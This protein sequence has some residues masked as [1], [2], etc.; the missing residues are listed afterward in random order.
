MGSG[1]SINQKALKEAEPKR[2]HS[3][4]NEIHPKQR[5][6]RTKRSQIKPSDSTAANKKSTNLSIFRETQAKIL[7]C[8]MRPVA[9]SDVLFMSQRA[10]AQ[11]MFRMPGVNDGDASL[12]KR[13]LSNAGKSLA[14][15]DQHCVFVVDGSG[16]HEDLLACA[17]VAPRQR[18]CYRWQR[19]IAAALSNI[20]CADALPPSPLEAILAAAS[21]AKQNS[22]FNKQFRKTLEPVGLHEMSGT[23]EC[24]RDVLAKIAAISQSFEDSARS[25][26]YDLEHVLRGFS[27]DNSVPDPSILEGKRIM[28]AAS[29]AQRFRGY[30]VTA[31]SQFVLWY[32]SSMAPLGNLASF[33]SSDLSRHPIPRISR[34]LPPASD[35]PSLLSN[36]VIMWEGLYKQLC[37]AT[38]CAVEAIIGRNRI[39]LITE[40]MAPPLASRIER[41]GLVFIFL[42]EIP[43]F[44]LTGKQIGQVFGGSSQVNVV[45]GLDSVSKAA[46]AYKPFDPFHGNLSH[47]IALANRTLYANSDSL[48]NE[49]SLSSPPSVS[50]ASVSS[51]GLLHGRSRVD[52]CSFTPG[53]VVYSIPELNSDKRRKKST[54]DVVALFVQ[55]MW[56]EMPLISVSWT[57]KGQVLESTSLTLPYAALVKF[58]ATCEDEEYH[59]NFGAV[60]CVSCDVGIADSNLRSR[61]ATASDVSQS[62]HASN[63]SRSQ[64]QI[65]AASLS[66]RRWSI[67]A[68]TNVDD[69]PESASR[70]ATNS[71]KSLY[72]C[73]QGV[74]SCVSDVV[75]SV[76]LCFSNIFDL[77]EKTPSAPCRRILD[78]FGTLSRL[79]DSHGCS[80]VSFLPMILKKTSIVSKITLG[81]LYSDLICQISAGAIINICNDYSHM[82][83]VLHEMYSLVVDESNM[84]ASIAKLSIDR[85]ALPEHQF[86][87]TG[88]ENWWKNSVSVSSCAKALNSIKMLP[89]FQ[90]E[91]GTARGN[92]SCIL[93][94]LLENVWLSRSN[95]AV[96]SS[97]KQSSHL[98]RAEFYACWIRAMAA[99]TMQLLVLTEPV[100]D[101]VDK[102]FKKLPSPCLYQ[103]PLGWFAHIHHKASVQKT[104]ALLVLEESWCT[105]A[106]K[107]DEIIHVTSFC[108]IFCHL[109]FLLSSNF[110]SKL[111]R[112]RSVDD[113]NL[114][115]TNN[116]MHQ[117]PSPRVI[118]PEY[119][120]SDDF[121]PKPVSSLT[122]LLQQRAADLLDVGPLNFNERSQRIPLASTFGSAGWISPVYISP[123]EPSGGS[124]VFDAGL[125]FINQIPSTSPSIFFE[126]QHSQTDKSTLKQLSEPQSTLECMRTMHS[127]AL[128][129]LNVTFVFDLQFAMSALAD[130]L[131]ILG[132]IGSVHFDYA[133]GTMLPLNRCSSQMCQDM[134]ATLYLRSMASSRLNTGASCSMFRMMCTILSNGQATLVTRN[135]MP[136]HIRDFLLNG[137][138]STTE[139]D[140]HPLVSVALTDALFAKILNTHAVWILEMGFQNDDPVLDQTCT[141]AQTC[142]AESVQ[143]QSKI[144]VEAQEPL[145]WVVSALAC[146]LIHTF[147]SWLSAC[148]PEAP[149]SD[150]VVVTS[151]KVAHHLR[152]TAQVLANAYASAIA[153][154]V[155]PSTSLDV[156]CLLVGY[157]SLCCK[158]FGEWACIEKMNIPLDKGTDAYCPC[159]M[160]FG[161]VACSELPVHGFSSDN[162]ILIGSTNADSFEQA[163]LSIQEASDHLLMPCM[164]DMMALLTHHEHG[165][166]LTSYDP[167]LLC[168]C[169]CPSR[170]FCDVSFK[171]LGQYCSDSTL[172]L[173]E[174]GLRCRKFKK[175]VSEDIQN[176]GATLMSLNASSCLFVRDQSMLNLISQSSG[177]VECATPAGKLQCLCLDGCLFLT[178]SFTSKLSSLQCVSNLECLVLP[179]FEQSSVLMG[180]FVETMQQK[181]A[182]R[183]ETPFAF[184]EFKR[185]MRSQPEKHD[186]VDL[187]GHRS[188]QII[189][190]SLIYIANCSPSLSDA[191]QT[192]LLKG[193]REDAYRSVVS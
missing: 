183:F 156:S 152:S 153:A 4:A 33:S 50:A 2:L 19:A 154:S 47:F 158:F 7:R 138:V 76:E 168:Y 185:Q 51:I 87:C 180:N 192:L 92:S 125:N 172:L 17:A 91:F 174:S 116:Y 58:C 177:R 97:K 11:F 131:I 61:P 169:I 64:S 48:D 191:L 8:R 123:T 22:K 181:V 60:V 128:K 26:A 45:L 182:H 20:S 179:S 140:E 21:A 114:P 55:P 35:H 95:V 112:S 110:V 104:T 39:Q 88:I 163:E 98:S 70:W 73:V 127:L 175:C 189:D 161:I 164:C 27:S 44:G 41:G 93:E 14:P 53:L 79:R 137:D 9:S 117:D 67:L 10:C 25:A 105:Q 24:T 139:L 107:G 30:A 46:P 176:F 184:D 1:I 74:R 120:A 142:D 66:E 85:V 94:T 150:A 77:S 133:S 141:R 119:E 151:T 57:S 113:A 83:F 155:L 178:S 54:G 186:V 101:W 5:M 43:T 36:D 32:R 52:S 80:D 160:L 135:F 75:S 159:Q 63:N 29:N 166:K 132:I 49:S 69:M 6:S 40:I 65:N 90:A 103:R 122:S 96:E 171:H 59:P 146:P 42:Q 81:T 28:F 89:L 68:S 100:D 72:C 134:A 144:T 121:L 13:M 34:P 15:S 170:A 173:V 187:L 18:D 147:S 193:C 111:M 99:R 86:R 162:S 102:K 16:L 56:V 124:F 130:V 108:E 3:S 62:S 129:L 84:N 143:I 167:A 148:N 165:D 38:E 145:D 149:L 31:S 12:L 126:N 78:L 109:R 188:V 82:R 71:L 118:P 106:S 190:P 115:P 37:I 136:L 23:E 157:A